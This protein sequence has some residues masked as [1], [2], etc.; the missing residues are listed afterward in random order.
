MPKVENPHHIYLDIEGQRVEIT[1]SEY[2]P[3]LDEWDRRRT[4]SFAQLR[5]AGFIPDELLDLVEKFKEQTPVKLSLY[6][7]GEAVGFRFRA[8]VV[9][10]QQQGDHAQ[11]LAEMISAHKRILDDGNKEAMTASE[12]L[13]YLLRMLLRELRNAEK[14]RKA[15]PVRTL[16]LVPRSLIA[17]IAMDL[18]RGCELWARPPG[19]WLT[20]LICE[21]LNLE[22]DKQGMPRKIDA[23]EEA[24][25]ILA[26]NP[27]VP[28]RELARALHVNASTISRWRRSPDFKQMVQRK[29]ESFRNSTGVSE[30]I[31]Q[32]AEAG[33]K[34]KE[35]IA[36]LLA[37]AAYLRSKDTD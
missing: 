2:E 21:L 10:S 31:R 6:I 3:S 16:K 37:T 7:A 1:Q 23:Q 8:E 14:S 9:G 29:A 20:N 26:Q 22:Q 32:Y 11:Y 4:E 33:P 15:A 12:A 30:K 28:T 35:A 36:R 19:Y 17:E 5:K 34:Q 27:T 13:A 25:D 24:A 18:L